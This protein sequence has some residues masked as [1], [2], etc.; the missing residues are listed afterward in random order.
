MKKVSIPILMLLAMVCLIIGMT[1]CSKDSDEVAELEQ[2]VLDQQ[3]TDYLADSSS[4]AGG[5]GVAVAGE[6]DEYAM[7]PEAAPEEDRP[8]PMPSRPAGSGYTVQVAA[9][10]NPVYAREQVNLFLDRGYEAYVTEIQV[11]GETFY[12]IRIGN[13]ETLTEARAMAMELHDKFSVSFWIDQN[14]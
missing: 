14:I 3:G 11:E 8:A 13:Y 6:T 5:E 10:T 1:G 7:T 2:E 9:G 4:D 12:R